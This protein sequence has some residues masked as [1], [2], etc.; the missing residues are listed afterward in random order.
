MLK[1]R[2]FTA[3]ILIAIMVATLYYLPP[4]GFSLLVGFFVL[5]ASWEWTRLIE[6]TRSSYR[7]TYSILIAG[8]GLASSYLVTIYPDRVLPLVFIAAVW[9][10]YLLVQLLRPAA[11]QSAVFVSKSGKLLGGFLILV[12]AWVA[13][14]YLLAQEQGGP[15]T[16]LFVFV[17]VWLADSAAYFVGKAWGKTKLAPHISPGKSI[18]GVVG[19][20]V[21]ALILGLIF[22]LYVWDY[23]P[24]QLGVFLAIVLV[25][26]LFSVAG[27]LVES[28]FKRLAG[29]KDSGN[30]LPG[31]GGIL[32]RVDAFTAAA[33]IFVTGWIVMLRTVA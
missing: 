24:R 15:T 27:D 22:A 12:P 23:G 18:E 25:T 32:D 6:M 16:V 2:L 30:F 31:H 33:P 1:Q 28:K 19:G 4:I 21:A 14:V 8:L 20:L 9:W 3:I 10:A 13:I 26:A 29:V 17:L 7:W 11:V 5:L